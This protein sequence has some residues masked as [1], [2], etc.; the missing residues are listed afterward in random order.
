[1][2]K[3][4][5]LLPIAMLLC[6]ATMMQSCLDSDDDDRYVICPTSPN[7]LVTVCPAEDG[8]FAMI[9]DDKTTLYPTNMPKSPFGQKEVR[10]L[11]N[12]TPV[13]AFY[14]VSG[15]QINRIDSIRTKLPVA[16]L[17]E[18]N[19]ETYG[20]DPIEIVKDW[21][22]VAEDGYLTLRVRTVWG[23]GNRPHYL[24]LVS[25]M[26]P[27]DPFEVELRQ[28]AQGDTEGRF[29]DALIAFNLN[30]LSRSEK[31]VKVKLH[32]NSFSGPKSA[33]FDLALRPVAVEEHETS[34][35]IPAASLR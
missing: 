3:V 10:A 29:A 19:N 24:N 25:G 31:P 33:E 27:D 26:N 4:K 6:S 13:D 34:N 1:M 9:L 28:D 11:V 35:L 22:T 14:G 15:V 17:R 21:V 20:N 8:S 12:Y 16:D 7:A 5:H 23:P 32:W 30:G 2:K 18:S